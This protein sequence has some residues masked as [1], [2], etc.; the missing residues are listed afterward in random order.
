MRID[1]PAL[2]T[3]AAGAY[4]AAGMEAATVAAKRLRALSAGPVEVSPRPV[5]PH[6]GDA[7]A[8]LPPTPLKDL[9]SGSSP[10]LPWMPGGDRLGDRLASAEIAGPDGL[11]QAKD[12]R[13]GVFLQAPQTHYP[14]HS[15]AAEELYLV[16]AGAPLWQKDDG[17]FEPVLPG[18][19]VHHL[20][21]QRHAMRTA[22]APLLAL[23]LWT[24]DLSF[25]TYRFHD[26]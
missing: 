11:L 26:Q 17:P 15:H 24:G 3:A 8:C 20:S 10:C 18:T 9:L 25:A 23:W 4:A 12:L 14:S 6:L 5:P 22:D 1:L 19:A 2:I 21:Y 7:L 13:F 16:L